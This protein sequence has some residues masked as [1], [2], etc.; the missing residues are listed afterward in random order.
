[1]ALAGHEHVTDSAALLGPRGSAPQCPR[2]R[3]TAVH[4][5]R[6]GVVPGDDRLVGMVRSG[7]GVAVGRRAPVG[8]W[9]APIA[10]RRSPPGSGAVSAVSAVSITS[11]V[12]T[13]SAVVERAVVSDA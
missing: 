5:V 3:Q 4:K 6:A 8:A 11:T 7:G 13:L 2:L 10:S 9:R 1:M 12:S